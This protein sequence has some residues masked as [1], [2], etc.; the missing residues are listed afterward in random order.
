MERLFAESEA[1]DGD[2]VEG[3]SEVEAEARGDARAEAKAKERA[4]S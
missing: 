3:V 1:T 4:R 2:E